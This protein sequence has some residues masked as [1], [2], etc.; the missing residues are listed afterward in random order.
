MSAVKQYVGTVEQAKW[1]RDS[2]KSEFPACKFSVRS[3]S[4]G[5]VT[6]RWTDGPTAKAVK[7][8]TRRFDLEGFDGMT[9]MRYNIPLE[10]DGREVYGGGLILE[11]RDISDEWRDEILAEFGAILE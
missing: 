8:V 3:A 11:Q 1:I 9:D 10:I 4:G 5:A 6:I 7:E 2:L